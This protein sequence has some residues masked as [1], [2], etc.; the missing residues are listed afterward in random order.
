MNIEYTYAQDSKRF[1]RGEGD[2]MR[3]VCKK[4]TKKMLLVH[5]GWWREKE[6]LDMDWTSEH[7]HPKPLL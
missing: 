7:E 5:D 6:E 2:R 1:A 3:K 4:I